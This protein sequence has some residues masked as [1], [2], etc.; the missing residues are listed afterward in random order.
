MKNYRNCMTSF[1]SEKKQYCYKYTKVGLWYDKKAKSLA[2]SICL[3]RSYS[4]LKMGKT[5]G[6]FFNLTSSLVDLPKI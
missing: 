5:I 2:K 4:S 3:F 1:I 6:M